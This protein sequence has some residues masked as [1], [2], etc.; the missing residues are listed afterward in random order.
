MPQRYNRPGR[1]EV[2]IMDWL[3]NLAEQRMAKAARDGEL[4]DLPGKGK[5]LPPDPYENVSPGMRSAAIV[6]GNNG[7]VPEE[8]DFLREMN[9][10]REALSQAGTPDQKEERMRVFRDAELRY[11]LAMDRHRRIF[12]EF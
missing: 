1:K 4:D 2:R 12:R 10:A 5:P 3:K 8:V 6:M 7:Y 9:E 11:N